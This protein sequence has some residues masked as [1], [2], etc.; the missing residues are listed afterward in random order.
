MIRAQDGPKTETRE[1]IKKKRRPKMGS[2]RPK[3]GLN[4]SERTLR[5]TENSLDGSTRPK[6][7]SRRPK[8]G[9]T[10]PECFLSK[11]PY[12]PRPPRDRFLVGR[13]RGAGG[14]DGGRSSLKMTGPSSGRHV[15]GHRGSRTANEG[16]S[17]GP[18]D[19]GSLTKEALGGVFC[20]S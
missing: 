2:R 10:L 5:N 16:L 1:P 12:V 20:S 7:G 8:M 17:R 18:G 13:G 15:E 11:A 4:S 6:M 3:M 9:R 14:N 19:I